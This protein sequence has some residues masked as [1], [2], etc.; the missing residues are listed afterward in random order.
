[1]TVKVQKK[2]DTK[3]GMLPKTG[4]KKH[5]LLIYSGGFLSLARLSHGFG[6]EREGK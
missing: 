4:E 1:M 3:K 2:T 6:E 5:S